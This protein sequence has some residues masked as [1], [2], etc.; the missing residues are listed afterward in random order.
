M[1]NGTTMAATCPGEETGEGRTC[2]LVRLLLQL[3]SAAQRCDQDEVAISCDEV[4]SHDG[5][6]L[7]QAPVETRGGHRGLEQWAASSLAGCRS[8]LQNRLQTA[9]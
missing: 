2:R 4:A 9:I 5:Q 8:L 6:R 3:R 1:R 7:P